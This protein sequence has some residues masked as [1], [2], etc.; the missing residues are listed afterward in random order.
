M[1]KLLCGWLMLVLVWVTVLPVAGAESDAY[2]WNGDGKATVSD[3]VLCRKAILSGDAEAAEHDLN[4]DGELTVTDVVLLRKFILQQPGEEDTLEIAA[5]HGN[6]TP[7]YRYGQWFCYVGSQQQFAVLINGKPT[8]L[9]VTWSSNNA[10]AF[11]V[12]ET[13]LVTMLDHNRNALITAT[14]S[15]GMS[16]SVWVYAMKDGAAPIMNGKEELLSC[17]IRVPAADRAKYEIDE[18]DNLT[19]SFSQ[20]TVPLEIFVMF[21]IHTSGMDMEDGLLPDSIFVGADLQDV[22][23]QI[24]SSDPSVATMDEHGVVTLHN[25]GRT[26]IQLEVEDEYQGR[27]FSD[28]TMRDY[29]YLNVE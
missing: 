27:R 4:E 2:D 22:P 19:V 28:R 18:F 14:L 23:F 16:I 6:N 12:D 1:K 15:N 20:G 8:D 11:S 13:G 25:P 21:R 5:I 10:L 3:V 26:V 29:I 24:T 9:P 17:H 7:E